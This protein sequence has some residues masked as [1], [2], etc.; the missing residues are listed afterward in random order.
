MKD[1][2]MSDEKRNLPSYGEDDLLTLKELGEY[3]GK[4][5]ETMRRWVH[6]L[7][8]PIRRMGTVIVVRFGD[9]KFIRDHYLPDYD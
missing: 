3:V 8:I 6:D 5:S 1:L 7:D 9:T 4:S 2:I